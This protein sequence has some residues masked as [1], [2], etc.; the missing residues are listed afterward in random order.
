MR[1]IIKVATNNQPCLFKFLLVQSCDELAHLRFTDLFEAFFSFQMRCN[2]IELIQ[3]L[4]E[5]GVYKNLV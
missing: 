2:H 1:F 3:S 5:F 4:L